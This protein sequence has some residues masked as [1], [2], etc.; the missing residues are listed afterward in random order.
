VS[1]SVD[2]KDARMSAAV[3]MFDRDFQA[4]GA[5][6]RKGR[7]EKVVSVQTAVEVG[8]VESREEGRLRPQ[9]HAVCSLV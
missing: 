3:T 9:T 1:L 5:V 2:I 6:Q 4:L 8:T 7:P